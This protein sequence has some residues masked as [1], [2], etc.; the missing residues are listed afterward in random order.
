M[1]RFFLNFFGIGTDRNS[2]MTRVDKI[3]AGGPA[4][5][6]RPAPKLS[7]HR[8]ALHT[9]SAVSLRGPE[10]GKKKAGSLKPPAFMDLRL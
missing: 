3:L 6:L 9:I 4:L 10:K 5:H 2:K 1:S 7:N 8:G